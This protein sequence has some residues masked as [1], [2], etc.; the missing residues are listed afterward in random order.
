VHCVHRVHLP[1]APAVNV[2]RSAGVIV[3]PWPPLRIV[4]TGNPC[5]RLAVAF[6]AR[7][8]S[9][10]DRDGRPP[11]AVPVAAGRIVFARP[12]TR[13]PDRPAGAPADG[14]VTLPRVDRVH[15]LATLLRRAYDGDVSGPVP[16]PAAK[17]SRQTAVE[18][19]SGRYGAGGK[20][21]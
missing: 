16:Y 17:Q 21:K 19:P 18:T 15:D 8:P 7:D 3:L 12:A 20:G 1:T 14:A 4:A 13:P 10:R 6:T 5:D 11:L 9:P 2:A